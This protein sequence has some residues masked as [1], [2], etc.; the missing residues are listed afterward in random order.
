M[1]Q[2][3]LSWIELLGRYG[4]WTRPLLL[5]SVVPEAPDDAELSDGLL[6]LEVR[7]GHRKWVY[8]RCPQC[9]ER[10]QIP[11]AGLNGWKITVDWLRRPTLRPSIWQRGGCGAHF[12]VTRGRI[13]TVK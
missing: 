11:V 3:P 5:T 10:I 6:F 7:G 2:I 8:L 1:V 13:V 4:I 12:F 9:G